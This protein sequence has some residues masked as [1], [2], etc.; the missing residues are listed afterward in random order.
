MVFTRCG[1]CDPPSQDGS[2]ETLDGL[3]FTRPDD[4]AAPGLKADGGGGACA[5]QNREASVGL[6]RI[7]ALHRRASTSYQIH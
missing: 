4:V 1:V 7:V 3:A 6:G 5:V 2:V